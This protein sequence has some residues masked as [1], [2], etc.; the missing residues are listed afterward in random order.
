MNLLEIL[1]FAEEYLKKYSFSK[2]RFESEKLI[3]SV[4]HL[5]RLSLYVNYDRIL[6]E[7][8]KEQIKSYLLKMARSKKTFAELQGEEEIVRKDFQ[9]ENRILLRKSI[10][11]LEKYGVENPTTDAEYIFADVLEVKRNILTLYLNREILEEKKS[12]IRE[13]L[14]QRGKKRRPLQYILGKWEFYGYEFL[15][16]ERALIPRNDT[17]ILVEQTKFVALTK[18]KA[19]ILDIGTGS[20]AIAIVL[21]KEVPEA[22]VLGVD[23]S[24][25]A[26]SL[27]EE[28][29]KYQ[30][31]RN[32]SFL[33]SNLWE[34]LTGKTF[35][36]I[37]SNPPYIPMKEYEELMP[38]V[39][40][41]E[42]QNA[43]TDLG[44]GYS[45]YEKI[46]KGA[47]K[48][49]K[50]KGYLFFE[51]GYQQAKQV[52]EWM[53]EEGFEGLCVVKDYGGNQRVV[54][55]RKGGEL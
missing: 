2:S 39:R 16:D 41:Y 14:L 55:G 17:E 43:L 23:V 46:I 25:E 19:E 12:Q 53:E 4:L 5:D 13:K 38:E 37:V 28:N 9:E 50:E 18:D 3:A 26:L 24:E 33:K 44:D 7:E 36:I 42:P 22:T 20:G 1:Q 34:A 21:A 32:L 54:F 30:L 11:Y 10:Q 47:K 45:F 15:M 35:D 27:A 6:E 52:K 8:E 48:H 40:E 31:V 51:V 29:K 49:L